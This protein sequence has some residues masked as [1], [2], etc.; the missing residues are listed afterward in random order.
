MSPLKLIMH[1]LPGAV[2]LGVLR[3]EGTLINEGTRGVDVSGRGTVDD[4]EGS[5]LRRPDR[6][7]PDGTT[8]Y[9]S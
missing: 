3:I 2:A 6:S 4:R 5:I 7:L 1:L 9:V 8:V